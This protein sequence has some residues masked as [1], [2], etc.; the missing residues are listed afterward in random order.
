MT[1]I[2]DPTKEVALV[3]RSIRHSE[4]SRIVTLFGKTRGKFAVIAKGARKAKSG[5]ALSAVEPPG[6]LEV[7]VYFKPHRAVQTLGSVTVLNP[8]LGLRSDLACGACA[9][10]V[11]QLTERALTD[12]D[13][14]EDVFLCTRQA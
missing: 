3:L 5:S 12:G 14:N 1:R 4:S 13:P 11:E 7:L 6:L 9:A 8:F 2:S 10:A